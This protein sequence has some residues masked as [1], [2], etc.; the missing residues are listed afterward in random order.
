MNY[1]AQSGGVSDFFAKNLPF[2][3]GVGIKPPRGAGY[4]PFSNKNRIVEKTGQIYI[5]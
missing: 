4:Q 2:D 3:M 1:P 5:P